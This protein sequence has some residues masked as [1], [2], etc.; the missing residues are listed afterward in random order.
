MLCIHGNKSIYITLLGF[1]Q[2][3]QPLADVTTTA[4]DILVLSCEVSLDRQ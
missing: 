4:E 3:L 2:S 1:I